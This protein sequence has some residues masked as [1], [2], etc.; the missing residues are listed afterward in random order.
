MR[1]ALAACEAAMAVMQQHLRPG[2]TEQ[3][4]WAHLHAEAIR[5]GGEWIETRLLCSRAPIPGSRNAAAG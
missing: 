5:R 2:V 3:E 1:C 4:L